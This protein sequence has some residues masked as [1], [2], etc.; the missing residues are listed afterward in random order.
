MKSTAVKGEF[1]QRRAEG[2]SYDTI[3]KGEYT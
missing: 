3:T 1:I 2:Q